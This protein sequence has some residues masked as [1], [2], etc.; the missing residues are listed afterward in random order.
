MGYMQEEITTLIVAV[1]LLAN[2]YTILLNDILAIGMNECF[3]EACYIVAW[4]IKAKVG[5]LH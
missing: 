5:R 2:N 1:K 3:V 4:R